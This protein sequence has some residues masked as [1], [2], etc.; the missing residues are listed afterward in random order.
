MNYEQLS[1]IVRDVEKKSDLI[2]ISPHFYTELRLYIKEMDDELSNTSPDAP[3]YGILEDELKTVHK[4][5][6]KILLRRISK[7]MELAGSS[8][9]NSNIDKSTMVPEEYGMFCDITDV[10]ERMKNELLQGGN[11]D[12][13][14]ISSS[15]GTRKEKSDSSKPVDKSAIADTASN[16][17]TKKDK[18]SDTSVMRCD[19]KQDESASCESCKLQA[20]AGYALVRAVADIS[21]FTGP[22]GREYAL[23]KDDVATIPDAIAKILINRRVAVQ[24]FINKEVG[25]A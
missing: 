19:E 12:A 16:P 3:D 24:I 21:T 18:Q 25:S 1:S 22:D 23:L 17:I 14:H 13:K 2:K 11:T 9:L 4:F 15:T 7:I 8:I 6:D 10:V 5:A 20:W